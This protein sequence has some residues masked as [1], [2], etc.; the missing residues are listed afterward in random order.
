MTVEDETQPGFAGMSVVHIHLLFSFTHGS[1]QYP[2]ALVEWFVK[3]GRK[4][5]D[6]T[7]MWIAEYD[8]RRNG[9]QVY[10]VIHLDTI[11]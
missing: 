5:D 10:P 3:C 7:G 2:C 6:A 9:E 8:E 1:Q 11:F 4:P